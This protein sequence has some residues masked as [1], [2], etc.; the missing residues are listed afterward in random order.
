MRVCVVPTP[1]TIQERLTRGCL[2]RALSIFDC[3]RGNFKHAELMV[4]QPGAHI[5]QSSTMILLK[6]S[7]IQKRVQVWGAL[8]VNGSGHEEGGRKRLPST[9]ML[10]CN[11]VALPKARAEVGRSW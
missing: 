1:L 7:L 2:E 11:V 9:T 8:G 6:G 5:R 4:L 3:M 10:L